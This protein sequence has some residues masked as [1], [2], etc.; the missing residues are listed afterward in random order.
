[1]RSIKTVGDL[2]TINPDTY[3][4]RPIG[5]IAARQQMAIEGMKHAQRL[6]REYHIPETW[7]DE[8]LHNIQDIAGET[9]HHDLEEAII[10]IRKYLD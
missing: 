9:G 8:Y 2:M 3:W 5:A 10:I 7:D 1:M 4:F 6:V